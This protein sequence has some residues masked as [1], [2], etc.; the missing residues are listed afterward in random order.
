MDA[1]NEQ[2]PL[3]TGPPLP[4]GYEGILFDD[5]A[6]GKAE[7]AFTAHIR[8]QEGNVQPTVARARFCIPISL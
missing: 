1:S 6:V 4:N 3:P 2:Q 8:Q 5:A 7:V